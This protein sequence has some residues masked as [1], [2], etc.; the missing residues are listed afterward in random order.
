MCQTEYEDNPTD[1]TR[2]D[3]DVCRVFVSRESACCIDH[4]L[5]QKP[6]RIRF[7]V[8][9]R[10]VEGGLVSNGRNDLSVGTNQG[11]AIR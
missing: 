9:L 8:R 4:S 6:Q 11:V 1:L 7:F 2:Y 10:E 3:W 5:N